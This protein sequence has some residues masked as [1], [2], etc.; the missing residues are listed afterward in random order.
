MQ[1][2]WI[3]TVTCLIQTYETLSSPLIS[4]L[5]QKA[6]QVLRYDCDNFFIFGEEYFQVLS[7]KKV[8]L[9]NLVWP[10]QRRLLQGEQ[11]KRRISMCASFPSRCTHNQRKLLFNSTANPPGHDLVDDLL[12]PG[13]LRIQANFL[14]WLFQS[15]TATPRGADLQSVRWKFGQKA[16]NE[17][18]NRILVLHDLCLFTVGVRGN[19]LHLANV[20]ANG[21]TLCL[22]AAAVLFHSE[23]PQAHS[24][25]EAA[26][27]HAYKMR[28]FEQ[29]LKCMQV[30]TVRYVKI[31]NLPLLIARN[32]RSTTRDVRKTL[33]HMTEEC[34]IKEAE[35]FSSESFS[36]EA[37]T[38]EQVSFWFLVLPAFPSLAQRCCLYQVLKRQAFIAVLE[39]SHFPRWGALRKMGFLLV[40][41]EF[42]QSG[43]CFNKSAWGHA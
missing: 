9:V 5:D 18:W 4:S 33:L 20:A 29:K 12:H 16:S 40:K 25:W 42:T 17:I 8:A 36:N 7:S 41:R 27:T 24:Y 43:S 1:Q 22:D 35:G 37:K 31:Q 30:S 39:M 10:V 2:R 14:S 3:N 38:S 32:A 6:E 26:A 15:G 28:L 23:A 11:T 34:T 19:Q 21:P 13:S